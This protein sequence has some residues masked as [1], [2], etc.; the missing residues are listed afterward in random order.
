MTSSRFDKSR[1]PSRHTTEGPDRAPHRSFYY[2]M[3]L[4]TEEIHQPFIGVA[5]TW[6]ATVTRHSRGG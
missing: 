4:T 3:G 6:T 2:A 1:L 5:T